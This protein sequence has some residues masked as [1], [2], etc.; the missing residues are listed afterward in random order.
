MLHCHEMEFLPPAPDPP[1]SRPGLIKLLIT[2]KRN[3]LECWSADFFEEPIARV[4]LPF[5]EAF[6]VHDPGAIRRVLMDNSRNYRK[7]P[8]QR[9]VLS[10]GLSDGLLSVE[11]ERWE[12]QRRTIAPI[13]AYRTVASFAP[14]MLKAAN[15]LVT[16]WKRIA[17]D[18]TVDIAAEMALLTLN[19]LAL[20]IFSDG[21][22]GD[23]DDFRS[24]MNAYFSVV[25]RIGMLDLLG[26]PQSVPRPGYRRL[27]RT[28]AY[29]EQ[30]IDTIVDT[31]R[32]R[33]ARH[34]GDN[35]PNDLLTLLLQSMDPSTG[36]RLGLREVRSNI[37]TFLSAGHETTANALAWSIFL[38]SQVPEWRCRVEEEA[39]R[40]LADASDGLADRLVVTKAVVEEALRLYPPIAALSRA[41]IGADILGDTMISPRSLIVIAPYVLHRHRRLWS[42]PDAFDPARFLPGARSEIPRFAYLPFGIGPRTCIGASFA[43]QEATIMLALLTHNFEMRL[44]PDAKVWPMQRVTLRP[45]NGLPMLLRQRT[46]HGTEDCDE[47][48]LNATS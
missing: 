3:P 12:I 46:A 9:R 15:E 28:M 45:A 11:G 23:L 27:R 35:V 42:N 14:A 44:L 39:A 41:A 2:L 30:V 6:L 20:T 38:L 43:L 19:V 40:E 1:L 7:D 4:R 24:A 36:R 37:L 10:S 17:P 32:E 31:R 34:A 5:T 47:L 16:K 21:I 33:L 13:F 29:F 18:T 48:R 22:G 8:I 25:G 26:V